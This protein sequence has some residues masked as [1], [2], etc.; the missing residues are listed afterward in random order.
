MLHYEVLHPAALGLLKPMPRML[1]DRPWDQIKLAV[2]Y[3]V[4]TARS[5]K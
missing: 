2:G 1:I 5:I 4:K 3:A